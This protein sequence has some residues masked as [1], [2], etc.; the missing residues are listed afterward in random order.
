[1]DSKDFESYYE[2]A[3]EAGIIASKALMYG[4]KL[5]KKEEKIITIIKEVENYI[6]QKGAKPAFPAQISMNEIAAH[7]TAKYNDERTLKGIVKLDVGAHIDG[8]IADNALTVDLTNENK[9]LLEAGMKALEEAIKKVKVGEKIS[10]VSKKIE[11]TIHSYNLKPI[12][13]LSGHGLGRYKIHTDPSIPNVNTNFE[14]K[15][16]DK[17]H[18]AI[19]PFTT[20][21]F[22]KIKNYSEPEV[23]RIKNYK[24][25]RNIISKNVLKTI[26]KEYNLL[27]F[28]LRQIAEKIGLKKAEYAINDLILQNVLE[29]YTPLIEVQNGLVSQFERTII[30]KDNKP[31]I[32]TKWNIE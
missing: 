9:K 24:P 26:Y 32:T 21:G 6:I 29:Y 16:E 4:K 30:I 1:M 11:E 28:S 17:M 25:V 23:F 27:P 22:G 19:E 3:I 2:K 15:F 12:S 5:I 14:E 18:F 31:I 8:V 13:N 20:N 10:E 7:D